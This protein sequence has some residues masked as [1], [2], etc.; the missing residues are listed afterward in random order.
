MEGNNLLQELMNNNSIIGLA[1]SQECLVL[2]KDT[3]QIKA[4]KGVFIDILLLNGKKPMTV[5]IDQ[6]EFFGNPIKD[7]AARK[8]LIYHALHNSQKKIYC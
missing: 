6:I 4:G 8:L 7:A 1:N 3:L 5:R 2:I